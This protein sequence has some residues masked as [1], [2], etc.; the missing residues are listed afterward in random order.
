MIDYLLKYPDKLLKAF[1]GHIEIVL[2][3][4][5]ISI[6]LAALLTILAAYS[7][8]ASKLLVNIFAMIYSIPSLALF[9]ILVP[10]TGLGKVTAII[11]LVLYNQ[12]ILLRNTID[13]LNNVD[14]SI[15]EAATG[16]GMSKSQILF[17]IKLPL[18]TKPI[19][20]GIHLAVV[21]TIGIATIAASINAGGI[22]SVLLDGLR[23]V[24]TAKILWG[25]LM[26]AGLA[27][28]VNAILN[29]IE[30]KIT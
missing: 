5:V 12:Y 29:L 16:M 26:S 1:V 27:I 28:V 17:Q 13:G 25:T 6:I 8:I 2:I 11:V 19:F 14:A 23:T 10:I 18:V 9:A 30:K 20:A 3:T 15:V 22:G 4:L 7:K 21:S 24:N